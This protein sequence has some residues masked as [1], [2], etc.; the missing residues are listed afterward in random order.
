MKRSAVITG[1][2]YLTLAGF[3]T[4]LLGFVYRIYLSKLIGSEGMGLYQLISPIYFLLFTICCAGFQTA[5]SQLVAAQ[6]AHHNIRG[7]RRILF[8]CLVPAALFGIFFCLLMWQLS[9]WV[10]LHILHDERAAEGLRIICLGLPFCISGTCLKAY[11]HGIMHM[12]VPAAEQVIEQIFRMTVIYLVSPLLAHANVAEACT[13]VVWGTVAGDMVSCFFT[14]IL[15]GIHRR[16]NRTW[17]PALPS[18]SRYTSLLRPILIIVI[19]VT[20]SRMLTQLLS[21]FENIMLPSV[22][23]RSGMSA[24]S[25]LGL[26]GEFSG[27]VMPLLAFP[28]IVTTALS[29]NLLPLV[30]TAKA[31]GRFSVIHTAIRRSLRFTFLTS[32]LFAALLGSLGGFIGSALYP[33]TSAGELLQLL[34][35]Y[36]PF[37]YLQSTLGGLLNGSGLQTEVFLYQ[38]VSS[39]L[40]ICIMLTLVPRYGFPAFLLG[41]LLSL[42]LSS[43]LSLHKLLSIYHMKLSLFKGLAMPLLSAAATLMVLRLGARIFESTLSNSWLFLFIA[44]LGGAAFYLGALLL[45][46]S[47]TRQ[48]IA[49]TLRLVRRKT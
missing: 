20:G 17:V 47:L 44:C 43:L 30:A 40:R 35:L 46:R 38:F 13:L 36:C 15:Y 7:M 19:P 32:F 3:I 28:T 21:S 39:G 4:R 18:Q 41:M 12:G 22:L 5:I 6:N 23:Q 31:G 49:A 37:F 25:A 1:T 26:Y 16:K 8:V 10:A 29:S 33:G 11:F 24:S 48:D 45:S 34:A 27:M 14:L 9:P 2:F 42:I